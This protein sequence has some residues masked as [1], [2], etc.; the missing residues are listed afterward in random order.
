MEKTVLR[1]SKEISIMIISGIAMLFSLLSSYS[2]IISFISFLLVFV[3]S[4][5]FLIVPLLFY[6]LEK[7]NRE[8]KKVAG[9]YTS[10]FIINLFITIIVSVSIVNGLIPTLWK[11]LFDLVNLVILLSAL[12]IFIEQVLEYSNIKSKTYS[13][14]IMNIVY[15]VG[16]F[17]SYPFLM[18][19][20]KQI[21]KK[22][23]DED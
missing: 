3:R 20:N 1:L 22:D 11:S 14:T 21:N 17:L 12:F 5:I 16:N 4:F 23:N 6:I 8:F 19:I 9:I 13:L 2:P 7:D 10:Y 18:F 15:L